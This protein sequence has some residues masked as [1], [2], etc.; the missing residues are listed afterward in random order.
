L[1]QNNGYIN[2]SSS[3]YTTFIKKKKKP[4]KKVCIATINKHAKR[5]FLFGESM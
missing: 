1:S 4:F 3:I 2:I 5:Q